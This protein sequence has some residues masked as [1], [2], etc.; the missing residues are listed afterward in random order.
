[1]SETLSSSERPRQVTGKR[2]AGR[3]E[4]EERD[5][6]ACRPRQPGGQHTLR[7]SHFERLASAFRSLLTIPCTRALR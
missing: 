4:E 1:M 3:K 5:V 2:R 6:E 7:T